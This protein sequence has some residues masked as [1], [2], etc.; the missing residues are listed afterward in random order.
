MNSTKKSEDIISL[1]R[2]NDIDVFTNALSEGLDPNYSLQDGTSLLHLACLFDSLRVAT[3]LLQ[4]GALVNKTA[5]GIAETPLHMASGMGHLEVV[6]IL[7]AHG[8]DGNAKNALGRT[9]LCDATSHKKT[10][11]A[12]Y[13]AEKGFM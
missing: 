13:L 4:N 5:G 9:P 3:L 8:A 1:I 7:L 10:E 11:T 12:R 2:T 6:K